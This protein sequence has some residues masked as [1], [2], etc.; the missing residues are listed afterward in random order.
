MIKVTYTM[1]S[2][3]FVKECKAIC[4]IFDNRYFVTYSIGSQAEIHFKRMK[5]KGIAGVT[6]DRGQVIQ[7]FQNKNQEEILQIVL[8]DIENAP[9]QTLKE[10]KKE[11]TIKDLVITK[12]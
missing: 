7:R 4:R 1:M 5:Q 3:G 6:L 8:K 2:K 9:S 12:E 10:T 11:V